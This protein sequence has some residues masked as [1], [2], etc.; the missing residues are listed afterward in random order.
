MPIHRDLLAP[1]SLHCYLN[2]SPSTP[3]KPTPYRNLNSQDFDG[4]FRL[5]QDGL[6]RT[7]SENDLLSDEST[8]TL[9]GHVNRQNCRYWSRENSYWM[10]EL[11]TQNPEKVNVWAGII[12]GENIIGPF[13]IDG[14]LNP[15]N[16]LALKFQIYEVCKL[17]NETGKVAPDLATLRRRDL[18]GRYRTRMFF[19]QDGCLAHHAV[20]VRNWLN[21]EFNEHWIG[22][23]G[24]ILWPPRSPDL[25]ILDFY[26]WGR[27]KQIV[28]SEPLENDEEHLKF[29]K[30][31]SIE[32]F[33]NSFNEFRARIK[34]CAEKGGALFE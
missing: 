25:T 26:L 10:R 12:I 3:Q 4:N 34:I 11:H 19:Q 1:K 28:Y 2:N 16:Y 23:D 27:L 20:T 6:R 22:R 30:S 5:L 9:H 32:D 31:L 8:F 15:E 21:S 13:F 7:L 33:R 14:N 17:S 18:Q 24:P 29:Y